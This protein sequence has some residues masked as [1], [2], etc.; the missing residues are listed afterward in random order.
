MSWPVFVRKT[1]G[2]GCK[3]KEIIGRDENLSRSMVKAE[4]QERG[5]S[6]AERGTRYLRQSSW[7]KT[8]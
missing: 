4:N 1:K 3:V 2:F 6:N 7:L 5:T 8:H